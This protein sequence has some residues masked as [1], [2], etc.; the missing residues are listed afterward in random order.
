MT[1]S[2]WASIYDSRKWTSIIR[3]TNSLLSA[4][5]DIPG[6][7]HPFA[8]PQTPQTPPDFQPSFV[9]R[10]PVVCGPPSRSPPGRF[11]TVQWT[12]ARRSAVTHRR[13]LT[14]VTSYRGQTSPSLPLV[15]FRGKRPHPKKVPRG[16]RIP[17]DLGSARLDLNLHLP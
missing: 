7:I 9:P 3:Y 12:P 17:S 8:F 13:P 11:T 14:P 1:L 10:M 6:P 5:H 2:A 16:T 4:S 15:H